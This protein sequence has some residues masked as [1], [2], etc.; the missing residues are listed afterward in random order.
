ML[1]FDVREKIWDFLNVRTQKWVRPKCHWNAILVLFEYI[2]LVKFSKNL[3]NFLKRRLR[4]RLGR[5][6][7]ENPKTLQSKPP[8]LGP[9]SCNRN[10]PL[11]G[12]ETPLYLV[13]GRQEGL[14]RG[15][16]HPWSIWP[17]CQIT[18]F[19]PRMMYL[20]SKFIYEKFPDDLDRF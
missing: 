2:N 7:P 8:P 18:N 19:W 17:P 5:F 16:M 3:Q 20:T 15:L 11:G 10:P 13:L 12:S 9:K 4:R 6:A 14:G 1:I